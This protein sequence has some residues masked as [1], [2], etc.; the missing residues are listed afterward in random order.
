MASFRVKKGDTFNLKCTATRDDAPFDLTNVTIKAQM[1][2]GGV[3][4]A[5]F[6][7]TKEDAAAGEFSLTPDPTTD[8]WPISDALQMDIEYSFDG[9]ILH[10]ETFVI[11]CIPAQTREAS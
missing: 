4:V 2:R 11:E 10:T 7:A 8:A 9:T 1:R 3:L 5:T 6:T